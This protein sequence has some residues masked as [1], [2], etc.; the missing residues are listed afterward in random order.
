MTE[1]VSC[2]GVS[3]T[4]GSGLDAV[5]VLH[6]VTCAVGEG[7][8]IAVT[9]SSGSGKTTLLHLLAGLDEPTAGEIH[10]HDGPTG[11]DVPRRDGPTG[12]DAHR[13]D[14]PVG[15]VFQGPSLL[16]PLDVT[17]NVALPLL[18]AGFDEGG[19]RKR[20][21]EALRQVGL[22]DLGQRLPEELSGGQAQ[23]VAVARVLA[24]AP[25]LIIADEPTGQLDSAHA[26][27]V[28]GL[29][30]GVADELGAGLVIATHDPAI[31]KR[32][33]LRWEMSDGALG[34]RT[35]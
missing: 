1:I 26:D 23:R 34:R 20:A 18:I 2:T 6:G 8:K 22:A 4:Y 31:A 29:L 30:I 16:S 24:A 13:H 35:C 27:D 21:H 19:A 25:R 7:D 12:K 33:P 10:R 3:R 32:F 11:K 9:G 15:I 14:L 28:I 17:E 5:V